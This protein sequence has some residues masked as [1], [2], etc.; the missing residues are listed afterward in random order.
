[1]VPGE[2]RSHDR[3]VVSYPVRVEA[4]ADAVLDGSIE[5]LGALGA[6]VLTSNLETHLEVGLEVRLLIDVPDG[7]GLEAEG[8]ILRLD[9][10]FAAG[11][12]RRAFAVK[13]KS[14]LDL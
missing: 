8:V 4:G 1:M 10:E 11:E 5:N 13:F 14:P 9:Q 3:R 7:G 2:K 6:L 12:I